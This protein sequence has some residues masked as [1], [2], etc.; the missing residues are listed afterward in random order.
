MRDIEFGIRQIQR[1]IDKN[2]SNI[3][4]GGCIHFS[5]Y[6][7]RRL[8]QLNVNN[9]IVLCDGLYD[10]VRPSGYD[11]FKAVLHVMVYIPSIGYIDGGKNYP[12]T[13]L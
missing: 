10:D 5:Y 6:L 9:F 1:Y 7:S 4:R 13:F 3:N 11:D 8:N 12:E 2:I